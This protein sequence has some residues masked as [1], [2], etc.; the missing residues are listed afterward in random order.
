VLV[1]VGPVALG[2][3]REPC[4]ADRG[5]ACLLPQSA[6][7]Q[8]PLQS[9]GIAVNRVS[10]IVPLVGDRVLGDVLAAIRRQTLASLTE[11]ILVAPTPAACAIAAQ[12]R[13]AYATSETIADAILLGKAKWVYVACPDVALSCLTLERLA[14]LAETCDADL[15]VTD[16]LTSGVGRTW[17]A[18]STVRF[19]DDRIVVQAI[20][21]I[22]MPGCLMSRRLAS[23]VLGSEN[24]PHLDR[25]EILAVRLGLCAR[26]V[27]RD[28]DALVYCLNEDAQSSEPA[29]LVTARSLEAWIDVADEIS[30]GDAV[31]ALPYLAESFVLPQLATIYEVEDLGHLALLLAQNDRWLAMCDHNEDLEGLTK[32]GPTRELIA[33]RNMSPEAAR[34]LLYRSVAGAQPSHIGAT[35]SSS[36]SPLNRIRR[37]PLIWRSRRLIPKWIRRLVK[38][39]FRPT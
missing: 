7:R 37:H 15:A 38:R 12:L 21:R 6:A 35:S 13:L 36:P 11:V 26:N 16:V 17:Q 31:Y 34:I 1:L 4:I 32:S 2:A 24:S 18:V 27:V 29:A 30:H 10:V 25:A 28:P 5:D 8:D 39:G 22:R 23:E 20:D 3:T 33:A 19:K 9:D 14:R